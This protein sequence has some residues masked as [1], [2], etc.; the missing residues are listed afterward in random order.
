MIPNS[1]GPAIYSTYIIPR[2]QENCSEFR[3]EYLNP[4]YMTVAR[5]QL[6]NVP[7]EIAFNTEFH[8]DISIPPH[9]EK[10]DMKGA[11]VLT[12]TETKTLIRRCVPDSRLD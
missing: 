2:T 1:T 5:P 11:Q 4:P 7:K 12:H 6:S 9:L 8:V 3:V 10:E